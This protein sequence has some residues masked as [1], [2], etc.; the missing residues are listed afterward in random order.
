MLSASFQKKAQTQAVVITVLFLSACGIKA[1]TTSCG[2]NTAQINVGDTY[3]QRGCGC[4][5]PSGQSYTGRTLQCTVPVNT[6][7]YFAFANDTL[8]HQIT[9][10]LQSLA[11]ITY[12]PG[13]G[14]SNFSGA[15]T[16]GSMSAGISFV[17]GDTGNGGSIVVISP[18]PVP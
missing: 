10:G 9:F 6:V 8:S 7:I 5:E 18:T 15:D 1:A 14:N 4:V 13:P 16:F 3:V 12:T 2:A 17:D 11:P